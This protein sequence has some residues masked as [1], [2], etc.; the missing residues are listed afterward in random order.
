M[1]L[2]I[3]AVK[4]NQNVDENKIEIIDKKI[5]IQNNVISSL[6]DLLSLVNK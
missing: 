6:S 1:D 2:L 4:K 5:D 3:K